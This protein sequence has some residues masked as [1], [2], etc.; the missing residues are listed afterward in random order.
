MMGGIAVDIQK[1]PEVIFDIKWKEVE[2]LRCGIF[3]LTVDRKVSAMIN[4]STL[5]DNEFQVA[6]EVFRESGE[7]TYEGR[8]RVPETGSYRDNLKHLLYT[9]AV[10]AQVPECTAHYLPYPTRRT[11]D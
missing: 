11:G 4:F 6:A 10:F 2:D 9:F 3:L 5:A 7:L 8:I 1:M